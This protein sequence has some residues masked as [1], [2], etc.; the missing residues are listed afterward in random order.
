MD[1]MNLFATTAAATLNQQTLQ[2]N[3]IATTPNKEMAGKFGK[4]LKTIATTDAINLSDAE[5]NQLETSQVSQIA[6]ML[7]ANVVLPVV[8]QTKTDNTTEQQIPTT[9]IKETTNLV[10]ETQTTIQS[11]AVKAQNLQEFL[12]KMTKEELAKIVQTNPQSVNEEQQANLQQTTK[13]EPIEIKTTQDQQNID[14]QKQTIDAKQI[15]GDKLVE[16]K[17]TDMILPTTQPKTKVAQ[18]TPQVLTDELTLVNNAVTT[19]VKKPLTKEL[20]Q[21]TLSTLQTVDLKQELQTKPTIEIQNQ[22]TDLT[23]TPLVTTIQSKNLKDDLNLFEEIVKKEELTFTDKIA[24]IAGET[25][26]PE[27]QKITF[28][29]EPIALANLKEVVDQIVEQAKLTQKPGISEMIL[30]LKP[31]NL[32]EM[33]IRIIAGDGGTITASFHT[34]N[35][36]A[37]AILQQSLPTIKQELA[38]TGL[39]VNDVG[40]YAGLGDFQ[41]FAQQ[42]EGQTNQQNSPKI[43]AAKLAM[44]DQELLEELQ[45]Q[46]DNT[47]LDGGVDYRI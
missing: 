22:L 3:Q 31:N 47:S 15:F 4:V 42:R 27:I 19:E 37:R 2:P 24:T 36:E 16:S 5:I 43:N 40:V 28:D 1:A 33:T 18:T 38:N 35:P 32:G 14:S 29:K 46:S 7:Q 8:L 23:K 45:A 39:K 26:Q 41:S 44:Q 9:A 10:K 6:S 17:T 11:L 25:K 30:R 21:N 13:N 20:E 34:N 12:S